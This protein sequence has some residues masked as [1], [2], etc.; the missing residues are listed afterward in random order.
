MLTSETHYTSRSYLRIPNYSVYHTNHPDGTAHGGTAI[1]IKNK[2]SHHQSSTFCEEQLQATTIIIENWISPLTIS[3]VYCPPRHF[4]KAGLFTNY[5]N[6]LGNRFIAGGDFNAKKHIHWGSRVTL[7]RGREILSTM[8]G[9]GLSA[10]ASGHPSYW[11]TD[12]AKIPDLLDFFVVRGISTN[13]L[14]DT[15]LELSSDHTPV[16]LTVNI[17]IPTKP[18]KCTLHNKKTDWESFCTLL[19]SSLSTSVRLKTEEDI[20]AAVE[21]FNRSVQKAAWES[22]PPQNK[23]DPNLTFSKSVLVKIAEKRRIRKWQKTRCPRVKTRLNGIVKD[24]KRLLDTERNLYRHFCSSWTPHRPVITLCGRSL[25]GSSIRRL[26]FL[27]YVGWTASGLEM[28]LRKQQPLLTTCKRYSLPTSWRVSLSTRLRSWN[29][30][31][32]L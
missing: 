12:G 28:T 25:A 20:E 29:T 23:V 3:T 26:P 15:S 13:Y 2:I 22:T 8:D 5:F 10:V 21:H 11:P 30:R 7:T 9:L 16:L 14:C 17:S 19:N 1:I 31:K 24:L 6:S 4:I 32:L 27:P 18:G